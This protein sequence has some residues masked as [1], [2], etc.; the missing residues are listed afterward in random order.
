LKLKQEGLV[1]RLPLIRQPLVDP[2]HRVPFIDLL[3]NFDPQGLNLFVT[4]S[5]K[6]LFTVYSLFNIEGNSS[7][8][9]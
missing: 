4:V 2:D 6:H 7:A 8:S 9:L 3:S 1:S 5:Q